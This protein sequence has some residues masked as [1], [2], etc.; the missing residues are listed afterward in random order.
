MTI[1]ETGNLLLS[2]EN[3]F[4][5]QKGG[6]KKYLILVAAVSLKDFSAHVKRSGSTSVA[7][8]TLAVVLLVTTSVTFPSITPPE[9][10]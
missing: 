3:H 10:L 5:I 9:V 7:S 8:W 2:L 4:V 6:L 1:S